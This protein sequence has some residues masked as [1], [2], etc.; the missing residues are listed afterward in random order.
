MS[1][2]PE[3]MD[4]VM[5]HI[6]ERRACWGRRRRIGRATRRDPKPL[7][8]ALAMSSWPTALKSS[9]SAAEFLSSEPQIARSH[10]WRNTAR[11][12][13][14]GSVAGA[15]KRTAW[16]P[17]RTTRST[18]RSSRSSE[19]QRTH[20][21]KVVLTVVSWFGIGRPFRRVGCVRVQV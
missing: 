8:L 12:T 7:Q 10:L 11:H 21:L 5:A 20:L 19:P 1:D 17:P 18:S 14:S 4:E 3:V 6:R 15:F 2:G 13:R 9:S 16:L